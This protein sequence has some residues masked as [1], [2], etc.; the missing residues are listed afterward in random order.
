[1]LELTVAIFMLLSLILYALMGGADFGGGMWDLL[2]A[3]PRAVRQRKA[4]AKAIGPIWEANHVWLILVVV[5]L[6]TG[7]PTGFAGMMTALNIPLTVMLI[8][9]V[10]RGSAFIFR[11][12]DS[13]SATVQRHWSRVFGIDRKSTR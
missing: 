8:G 4:I 12:Y 5:L 7:F 10:L 3:G 2:A 13:K 9:I 6:F 11:K 1:M